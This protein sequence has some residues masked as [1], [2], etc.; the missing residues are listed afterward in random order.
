MP[1]NEV[2]IISRKIILAHQLATLMENNGSYPHVMDAIGRNINS[3]PK[4]ISVLV[5]DIDDSDIRGMKI[6]RQYLRMKPGLTWFA[7]CSGD[8]D[9]VMQQAK[10]SAVAGF[11]FP[12]ESG[13]ALD[14]KR[15]A[16]QFLHGRRA[17][18]KHDDRNSR[19]RIVGRQDGS[20]MSVWQSQYA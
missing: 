20:G 7:L 17:S 12:S 11:F 14:Y 9:T 10:G 2:L 18:V 1:N 19:R 8:N 4:D 16:A 6:V 5:V 3:L 15:G 13:M